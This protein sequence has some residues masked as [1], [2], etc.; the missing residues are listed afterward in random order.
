MIKL[1]LLILANILFVGNYWISCLIYPGPW[2][3]ESYLYS[4]WILKTNIYACIFG[5]LAY[6]GKLKSK[7]EL[8]KYS[9]FFTNTFIGFCTSDIIDRIWFDTRIFQVNDY[10]MISLTM[11][12]SFIKLIKEKYNAKNT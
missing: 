12:V 1:I 5:I 7:N 4:W 9:D 10:L 6:A 2:I 8:I 3:S 11:I